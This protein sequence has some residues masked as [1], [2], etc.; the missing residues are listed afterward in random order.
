MD[1]ACRRERHHGQYKRMKPNPPSARARVDPPCVSQ[2]QM[3]QDLAGMDAIREA[4]RRS[5]S[6]FATTIVQNNDDDE[7]EMT[8]RSRTIT[9]GTINAYIHLSIVHTRV[10]TSS[11]HHR[12]IDR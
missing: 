1:D 8:T 2:N 9:S 11:I 5:N 12:Y 4:V 10:D 7:N 6:V 3:I